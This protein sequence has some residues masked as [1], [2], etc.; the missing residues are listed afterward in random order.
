[1]SVKEYLEDHLTLIISEVILLLLQSVLLSFSGI[2]TGLLIILAMAW[3]ILTSIFLVIQ[4]LSKHKLMKQITNDIQNI[5]QKYLLHEVI[6]KYGS[7][8]YMFY[9]DML[10]IGNKSMLEK[11]SAIRRERQEYQEF[12]EQWVHEIKTPIAAMKL[13]SENQ[14]GTKKRE[15]L[16]QL[17]RTE[18]YV[19]QA[20]FYARSEN[21]EK[22][23]RIQKTE[24]AACVSEALLRSKYSCR[25]AGIGI[26]MRVEDCIVYTDE[27]WLIFIIGQLIENAV[28]YRKEEG[29]CIR[30]W[31][32]DTERVR[33]LMIEDNGKGINAADLPRIYEKGFTGENGRSANSHST[34]IGLYLCKKLCEAMNIDIQV[35]SVEKEYTRVILTFPTILQS[36]KRNVI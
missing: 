36:C 34:G 31:N 2:E 35:E 5:D 30:I 15:L 17:E 16:G 27:K 11:V 6:P 19:E 1:M 22:D 25:S 23:F 9:R 28:K 24:V 33:K 7:N 3:M 13:W 18:H 10:R 21:V 26:D 32:E 29:A 12:V 20:L 8:E 14:E 4:Y